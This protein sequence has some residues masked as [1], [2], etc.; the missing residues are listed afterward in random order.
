[1][2]TAAILEWLRIQDKLKRD[3]PLTLPESRWL[4][5]ELPKLVREDHG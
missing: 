1:M 4:A 3:L 2:R 5:W